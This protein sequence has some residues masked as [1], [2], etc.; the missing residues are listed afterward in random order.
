MDIN[1]KRICYFLW[2]ITNLYLQSLYVITLDYVIEHVNHGKIVTVHRYE[3]V[4][5]SRIEK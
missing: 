1:F 5:T 3:I 4:E 2:Q